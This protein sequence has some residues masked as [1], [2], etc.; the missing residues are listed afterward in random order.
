[1]NTRYVIAVCTLLA[2]MPL[3]GQTEDV[4]RPGKEQKKVVRKQTRQ[5]LNPQFKSEEFL[6]DGFKF[7]TYDESHVEIA[8][9][10][11]QPP[12]GRLTLPLSTVHNGKTYFVGRIAWKA[13]KGCEELTE[14]VIS[15]KVTQIHNE[16][17]EGCKKLKVLKLGSSV[18]M[19][20]FDAIKNCDS[21]TAPIYNS[22]IFVWMPRNYKGEY[23]IPNGVKVINSKAFYGCNWL[24]SINIPNSVQK[25]ENEAFKNCSSLTT[26]N[27][28]NSVTSIREYAFENCS[29]LSKIIFP[30]SVKY[31]GTGVFHCCNNLKDAIYNQEIIVL[32]PQET[33]HYDIPEGIKIMA[34][35]AFWE[36]KVK[37]IQLPSSLQEIGSMA[38]CRS[39]VTDIFIPK[40]V[41][42]ISAMS[43]Y[44]CK[45]RTIRVEN[46]NPIYDSRNNCNAII[47]TA[48]NR[49]LV[50]TASTI[51]PSSIKEIGSFSFESKSIEVLNIPEGVNRI[52]WHSFAY[53]EI[54]NV[55]IPNSVTSIGGT[56]PFIGCKKLSSV[57]I[58]ETLVDNLY[59]GIFRDCNS[60]TSVTVR[61]A[62]GT[63]KNIPVRDDWK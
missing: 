18:D 60:L 6:A 4:V 50:G 38:F 25:I 51:I 11:S 39:L 29:S 56:D 32:G 53:S 61:C 23:S 28:P 3:W 15:E 63:T 46:G 57:S 22:I 36:S 26:L 8:Q 35:G 19:F 12:K 9:D 14:V 34:S 54:V 47:Q 20:Y 43:F 49:L 55:T 16:A 44:G 59:K 33:E 48:E 40:N 7:K 42:K 58:P 27:I 62:N 10:P 30:C 13:F 52:S 2:C 17:F 1:M 31:V 37:T 24:T 21:L 5:P 45:L 41:I